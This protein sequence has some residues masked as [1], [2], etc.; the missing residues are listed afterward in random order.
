MEQSFN[1]I[2]YGL[3]NS[4]NEDIYI[5]E[6]RSLAHEYANPQGKLTNLNMIGGAAQI[7][8]NQFNDILSS[9]STTISTSSSINSLNGSAATN[10][11]LMN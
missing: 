2:I 7:G 11:L 6:Y 10:P 5:E 9:T 8:N 1:G 3:G 4:M